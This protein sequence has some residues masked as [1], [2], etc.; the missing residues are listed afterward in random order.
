MEISN[1]T[2]AWFVVAAIAVSII[3]T[4]ASLTK[5]GNVGMTGYATSNVTGNASVNIASLTT[6]RFAIGTVDFGSGSVDT[7]A[8]YTQCNLTVND[9]TTGTLLVGTGCMGFN[10]ATGAAWPLVLEN[11]GNTNLNV[12]L[13]FSEDSTG[14]PGGNVA[15]RSFQYQVLDNETGSCNGVLDRSGWTE[16]TA[17][18]KQRVCSNLTWGDGLDTLKI[19]LMVYIPDDATGVKQVNILAQGSTD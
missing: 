18:A 10:N 15:I 17:L 14:F 11:A 12:T 6:L 16:I 9:S 2:L 7:S 4:G 19:N 3:G 8:G 1:N 13:N 5:L